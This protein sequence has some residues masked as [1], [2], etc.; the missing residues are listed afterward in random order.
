[1]E[2]SPEEGQANVS[3]ANALDLMDLHGKLIG[4]IHAVVP[5]TESD[6]GMSLSH[7]TNLYFSNGYVHTAMGFKVGPGEL[8]YPHVMGLNIIL[9]MIPGLPI[10]GDLLE[11]LP[12]NENKEDPVYFGFTIPFSL[13]TGS[14]LSCSGGIAFEN[15]IELLEEEGSKITLFGGNN[16]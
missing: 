4:A 3:Y 2:I 14:L 9:G 5:F 8:N 11:S 12:L 1:M 10:P 16:E 7:V 13:R 15:A 6:D